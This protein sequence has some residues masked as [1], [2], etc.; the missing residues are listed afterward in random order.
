MF[1]SW[2]TGEGPNWT[3]TL[4]STSVIY[5]FTL[6]NF[7]LAKFFSI[8]LWQSHI[9]NILSYSLLFSHVKSTTH[10]AS[11]KMDPIIMRN[12]VIYEN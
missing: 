12:F 5:I 6:G 1:F 3:L 8:L 10:Q 2:F 9:K 11:D 4:E 7:T